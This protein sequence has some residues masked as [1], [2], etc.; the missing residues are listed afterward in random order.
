MNN[1][2]VIK[3][4]DQRRW[5]EF[6]SNHSQGNIFQTPE[7]FDVFR[8]TKNNEPVLT[9][10]LDKKNNVIE[11]LSVSLIQREYSGAA[12]RLTARAIIQGG[13]LMRE[14]NREKELTGLLLRHYN[15]EIKRKA[16][17]SQYRNFWEQA[18]S[19]PVFR[20]HGYTYEEHLNL[21]IDLTKSEEQLWREVSSKRR[22]EIRRAK[23]EGTTVKE[24]TRETEIKEAYEI[25]KEVY[26]RA[27]LPLHDRSLFNA[28]Y[29]ILFPKGNIKF[30]GAFYEK[31]LIGVIVVLCYKDRVYDWYAGSRREYYK[32]YPNDLLPWEVFLWA[33]K[34]GYKLF[35]FGGAGKPGVPYGVRDY[36]KQYGGS[37]VNFG[38]HEKVHKPLLMKAAKLGLKLWQK[39]K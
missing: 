34:A 27:R 25:L 4:L 31:K 15:R 24:L 26:S 39:I 35:D 18:D 22:N 28:A 16:I 2:Y 10:L 8:A 38:R 37:F 19:I 12:G 6:V 32:K 5:A 3:Y 36:K 21:H 29:D 30:F 7:M 13:P 14:N 11:G 20:E 17:Y 1:Y 9:A 23:K 33:K